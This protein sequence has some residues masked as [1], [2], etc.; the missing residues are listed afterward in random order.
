MLLYFPIILLYGAF[1]M[2]PNQYKATATVMISGY[3]AI[4]FTL[5]H[6]Y[7]RQFVIEEEVLVAIVFALVIVSFSLVSNEISLLRKKLYRRNTEFSSAIEKIERMAITDDLTGLINRRHMM[8]MLKKQK[9]AA[10][11]GGN[12]FCVCF[13]DLD[14]FKRINDNM[15]HHVGDIVLKRFSSEV[16]SRLRESDIFARFGGEEFVLLANGVD[17]KRATVAANRL[18]EA[19][20]ALKFN[21][22]APDLTVTVSGGV[23]Q[24]RNNEKI[25]SVL[26]R[27]DQALYLAKSKGRNCIKA[28]TDLQ[29]L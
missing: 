1:S 20:E 8:Y 25:E 29:G 13:F 7:P 26:S 14:R 2:T 17:L 6:L 22:Y 28:E 15:G 3:A 10:D 19:V 11:R 16:Q 23:A 18:R 9:A 24:F 21:R 4:I 27:A 12:G 5:W